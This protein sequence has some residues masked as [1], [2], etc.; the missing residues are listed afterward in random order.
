VRDEDGVTHRRYTPAE[1]EA[2]ARE[3]KLTPLASTGSLFLSR[4]TPLADPTKARIDL[5]LQSRA[6]RSERT[7]RLATDFILASKA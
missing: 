1:A 7:R 3:A 6:T 4:K 2:L 5:W